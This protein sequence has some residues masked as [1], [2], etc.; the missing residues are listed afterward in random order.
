[1]IIR[2]I[3]G[4]HIPSSIRRV[5]GP[6]QPPA[7]I[8]TQSDAVTPDRNWSACAR[9]LKNCSSPPDGGQHIGSCWLDGR[10]PCAQKTRT[11][12]AKVLVDAGQIF[13][14]SCRYG[15][16]GRAPNSHIMALSART[17]SSLSTFWSLNWTR[18]T[19]MGISP[20]WAKRKV[21]IC[22]LSLTC[23]IRWA[24]VL[25]GPVPETKFSPA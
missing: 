7:P 22:R 15:V 18:H 10:Y 19:Y 20:G 3:N 23:S 6:A 13:S 1:M 12:Q 2:N 14:T 11:I 16:C 8:C 9:I 25:L 24:Q 5:T 21:M 4:R 17:T